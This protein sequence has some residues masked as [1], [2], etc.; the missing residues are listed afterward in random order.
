MPWGKDGN[1]DLLT[2]RTIGDQAYCR[3][4]GGERNVEQKFPLRSDKIPT[5]YGITGFFLFRMHKQ[6]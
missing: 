3:Y 1:Y 2:M 6:L 5:G 4:Y